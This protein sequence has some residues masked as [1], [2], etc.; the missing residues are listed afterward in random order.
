MPARTVHFAG[1]LERATKEDHETVVKF[2]QEKYSSYKS[3]C[4][5]NQQRFLPPEAPLNFAAPLYYSRLEKC[6]EER[7][8]VQSSNNTQSN[9]QAAG[10]VLTSSV[11]SAS[12]VNASESVPHAMVSSESSGL[13]LLLSG[14]GFEQVT[15]VDEN[16]GYMVTLDILQSTGENMKCKFQGALVACDKEPREL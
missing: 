10:P 16:H 15:I 2:V 14:G 8:I 1:I 13:N 5:T 9:L 7:S 4:D 12:S 11:P 6:Q 3:S